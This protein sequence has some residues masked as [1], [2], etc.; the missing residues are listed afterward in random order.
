MSYK[1]Y[2]TDVLKAILTS[3]GGTVSTRFY[4]M[5]KPQRVETRTSEE[6]IS[7]IKKKVE[8]STK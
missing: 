4:D 6:I 7:S 5:M 8:E 1:V 2:V 3:M